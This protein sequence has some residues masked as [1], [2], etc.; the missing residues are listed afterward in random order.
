VNVALTFTSRSSVN[1]QLPAPEQS[2]LQ[3]E[4]TAPSFVV[5]TSVT[6]VPSGNVAV[7]ALPQSM[8]GGLERTLPP[9]ET[10]TI[11]V[12]AAAPPLPVTF[13]PG[14]HAIARASGS[15]ASRYEGREEAGEDICDPSPFSKRVSRFTE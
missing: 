8:P 9:P 3:P 7:H 13:G 2:P 6:G 1:A 15:A 12:R 5:A 11:M 14:P 4:K 10:D